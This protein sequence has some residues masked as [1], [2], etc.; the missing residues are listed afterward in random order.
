LAQLNPQ[1]AMEQLLAKIR[2]TG[3]NAEFL[4]GLKSE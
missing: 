1:D 3:T 4:L 2:K